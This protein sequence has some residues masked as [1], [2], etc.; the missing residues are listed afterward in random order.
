M[1]LWW[2]EI[3]E[4]SDEVREDADREIPYALTVLKLIEL[5][6]AAKP[7]QI[8]KELPDDGIS[9]LALSDLDGWTVA[10]LDSGRWVENATGDYITVLKWAHL[11][12]E[13]E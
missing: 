9:V 5:L 7:I 12:G 4:E 13:E 2:E 8:E 3:E 1:K 10:Q 6:R 11:P